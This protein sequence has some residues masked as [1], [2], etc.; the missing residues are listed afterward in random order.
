MNADIRSPP[1][2]SPLLWEGF[3][4]HLHLITDL[5]EHM[6]PLSV[7]GLRDDETERRKRERKR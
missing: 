1:S 3:A 7:P 6:D 5:M 4:S 2:S